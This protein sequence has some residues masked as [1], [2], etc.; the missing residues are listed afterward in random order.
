VG[1]AERDAGERLSV[2]T[3]ERRRLP[4]LGRGN[5]ELKRPNEILRKASVLF[6]PAE[7]DRRVT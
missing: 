1:Q 4:A 2:T 5:M 3:D 7:L 6:A